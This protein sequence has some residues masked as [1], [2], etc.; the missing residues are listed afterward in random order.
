MHPAAIVL[1]SALA[2]KFCKSDYAPHYLLMFGYKKKL[3]GRGN[4]VLATTN[5]AMID[6]YVVRCASSYFNVIK[7]DLIHLTLTLTLTKLERIYA[8]KI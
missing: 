6:F 8:F 3:E 1:T 4:S 7:N 2:S 5:Y